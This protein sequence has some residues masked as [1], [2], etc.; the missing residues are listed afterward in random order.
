MMISFVLI[1]LAV[2][3]PFEGNGVVY[4]FMGSSTGLK[5]K[6]AQKLE[7]PDND[8]TKPKW[9]GYS[10]SRGLDIDGNSYNGK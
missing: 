5:D 7:S 9:F 4:I 2:G 1:D 8:L 6:W 3:A 10:L